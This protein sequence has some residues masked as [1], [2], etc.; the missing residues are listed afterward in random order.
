MEKTC[1]KCGETKPLD[2]FYRHPRMRDGHLN[3]CKECNKVDSSMRDPDK[4]KA[5]DKARSKDPKRRAQFLT[6]QRRR[7]AEHP[8]K[9]SAHSKLQWAVKQGK[10]VIPSLCQVCSGDSR[11]V[12]HHEDYSKPLE[13]IWM[14]EP[15]HKRHH[16]KPIPF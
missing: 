9:Q 10:I 2:G 14:C 3:K 8:E 16:M 5:Y 12:G 7:R 11:L 4:V 1:F 6:A 15:C 13:V